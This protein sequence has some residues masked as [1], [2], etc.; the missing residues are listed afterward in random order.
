[1]GSDASGENSESEEEVE[2]PLVDAEMPTK[3]LR[4]SVKKPSETVPQK[5]PPNKVVP[6][7]CKR[8]GKATAGPKKRQR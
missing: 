2:E 4:V 7:K 5:T 6:L 1:M 3:R 8:K